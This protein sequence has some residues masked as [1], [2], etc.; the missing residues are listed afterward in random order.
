VHGENTLVVLSITSSRALEWALRVISAKSPEN[1]WIVVDEK[2]MKILARRGL[3]RILGERVVVYSGKK[4][5]EFS[6]RVLVLAKPDELYVCD[7]RGIL[8]PVI[9][10]LRV[11]RIS[12][13]EC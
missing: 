13:Y 8:E 7:E 12:M 5:E 2:T 6:L 11:L 4:P 10:L 1:M 3:T 9:R